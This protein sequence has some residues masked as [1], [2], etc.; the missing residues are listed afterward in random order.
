[1]KSPEYVAIVT[2]IYRKALDG[3]ARGSW[4]PSDED[5]R[6][7]ALAFNREFTAGHL[8]GAKEVMGRMRSDNQGVLIGT[9]VSFD[10]QRN[11]AAVRLTGL[12]TPEQGDGLVF[13]APGQELGLVVQRPLQKDGLLRLKVPERV[14]PGARV[15]LTSSSALSRKAAAII[16]AVKEQIPIDLRISW[17][18]RTMVIEGRVEKGITVQVRAGFEMEV[19]LSRPLTATQIE[20]QLRRTGGTPFAV[21]KLEMSY[22]GGLFAP[23]GALNQ[24][25]R[26]LLARA[27]E[28]L[29]ES[30]RPGP[31]EIAAARERLV[32]MNLAA[33][34]A[35]RGP[36]PLPG[37]LRG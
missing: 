15:F 29:L 12:S 37:G 30:R 22:P 35:P 10:A 17:D 34:A 19:A 16:S 26:Q 23:L 24:L 3:I 31:E 6:E 25:R 4:A 14:R 36:R 21:R 18:D 13:I 5:E 8:L 9:V 1:M 2:S 32:G 7:L 20:A 28:A 33:P 27:Q 11:E